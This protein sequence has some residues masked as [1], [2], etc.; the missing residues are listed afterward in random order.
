MVDF[1][2]KDSRKSEYIMHPATKLAMGLLERLQA[3]QGGEQGAEPR[4]LDIG[5]GSG[6]LSLMAVELWPSASIIASDISKLAVQEAE[7]NMRANGCA[8]QV[9]CVQAEGLEHR[10]I[11]EG[12]PYDIILA[13][14]LAKWHLKYLRDMQ[15]ALKPDGHLILSG[16]QAWQL[17]EIEQAVPF[18]GL[19]VS[20]KA[21]QDG[22]VGLVL[23]RH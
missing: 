14:I 21:E 15:A 3:R 17:Q 22:W 7:E 1:V 5:C 8:K 19:G 16:I 9:Q 11:E 18:A 23:G 13:N 2:V 20:G 6:I 10:V 4:V 12:A